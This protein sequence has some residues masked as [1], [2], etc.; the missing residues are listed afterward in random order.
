[1]FGFILS[2]FLLIVVERITRLI[3]TVLGLFV[4]NFVAEL[5]TKHWRGSVVPA[6]PSLLRR[7]PSFN[8]SPSDIAPSLDESTAELYYDAPDLIRKRGFPFEQHYVETIDGFLLGLHRIPHGRGEEG[9]VNLEENEAVPA[10]PRPVVFLQHGFLQSSEAFLAARNNLPFQLAEAGFDVWLGNA[11]GNKYSAHHRTLKPDSDA[12]WDFCIDDV[13][14][15]DLPAAISHVLEHT[16]V[17]SLA[18]IGFS[19]GTAV[20]FACFS[21]RFDI[22]SRVHLFIALAPATTAKG[23]SQPMLDSVAKMSPDFV[24]FLLGRRAL[25]GKVSSLIT[26]VRWRNVEVHLSSLDESTIVQS[27]Y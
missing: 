9:G 23:F 3:V 4:P 5:V 24:Y 2:S 20:A 16:G 27:P 25:F 22:A 21:T 19:M 13:A 12:Y 18:Y 10:A 14:S 7:S 8:S 11:R 26:A 6:L 1:V 17:A 15:K